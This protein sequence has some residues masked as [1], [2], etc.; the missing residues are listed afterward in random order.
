[1]CS[2]QNNF[3]F[4]E[5]QTDL[6]WDW[7]NDNQEMSGDL[8]IFRNCRDRS[9]LWPLASNLLN[10]GVLCAKIHLFSC[11]FPRFLEMKNSM[12]SNAKSKVSNSSP[13]QSLGNGSSIPLF[14]RPERK[15]ETL[16][17]SKKKF[18]HDHLVF[19]PYRMFVVFTKWNWDEICYLCKIIVHL[20][21]KLQRE[22]RG[23]FML[24]KLT[25]FVEISANFSR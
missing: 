24:G 23:K 25:L 1:M 10:S 11:N 16:W 18:D 19:I 8:K 13:S 6:I 22:N 3:I 2:L 15:S 9:R 12:L 14:A 20:P 4:G 5:V 17:N 7:K 21:K